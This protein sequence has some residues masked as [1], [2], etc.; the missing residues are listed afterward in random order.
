M[1]T[2]HL[3]DDVITAVVGLLAIGTGLTLLLV[4]MLTSTQ[5]IN[6]SSG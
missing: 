2:H 3:S 4:G 1:K 6:W 5:S